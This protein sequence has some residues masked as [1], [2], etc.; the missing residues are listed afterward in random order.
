MPIISGIS[1]DQCEQK[2]MWAKAQPKWLIV[3]I[4][5]SYGWSVGKST[6]CPIHNRR[7]KRGMSNA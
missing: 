6:L 4:A 7:K 5:R 3:E 2:I 1:C